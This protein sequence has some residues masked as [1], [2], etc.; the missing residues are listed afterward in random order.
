MHIGIRHIRTGGQ[1]EA[2]LEQ[3]FL[4]TVG[5]DRRIGI[6]RLLVHRFPQRTTFYPFAQ[7][8][9]TQSLH[10]GIGLTVGYCGVNG[11]NDAGG[12]ANGRADNFLVSRI[13]AF[14]PHIGIQRGGTQP[15]IGIVTRIGRLLV[16]M[17]ARNKRAV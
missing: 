2:Y 9:H 16:K 12:S 4:H 14:Y 7:H 17:Y 8:E 6:D 13:L 10:V 5:I 15:E 1:T 11:M 3:R